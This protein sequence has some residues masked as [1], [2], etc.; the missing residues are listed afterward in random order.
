MLNDENVGLIVS[1][2]VIILTSSHTKNQINTL[3]HMYQKYLDGGGKDLDFTKAVT[4]KLSRFSSNIVDSIVDLV[5]KKGDILSEVDNTN[6]SNP[7][8][9]EEIEMDIENNYRDLRKLKEKLKTNP[10]LKYNR[11]FVEEYKFIEDS[12]REAKDALK[13]LG[14]TDYSKSKLK[15]I[16]INRIKEMSS[17]EDV[18]QVFSMF[19]YYLTDKDTIS[20][21]KRL[22][23]MYSSELSQIFSD[24]STD[25]LGDSIGQIQSQ[26]KPMI[27]IMG[28]S[29]ADELKLN[30]EQSKNTEKTQP[31]K[32]QQFNQDKAKISDMLNRYKK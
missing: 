26:L 21:F 13:N 22:G 19:L 24:E 32:N 8:S 5:D 7:L 11:D 1:L 6:N 29:I 16:A 4:I 9:K 17:N 23:K 14:V 31:N 20:S 18:I 30:S 15:Q 27:S 28:K 12:I 2:F 10:K 3:S 25:L